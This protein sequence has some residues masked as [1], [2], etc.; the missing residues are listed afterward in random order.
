MFLASSFKD[1]IVKIK[2][3]FIII[4][5][6]LNTW[7]LRAAH[8]DVHK[9]EGKTCAKLE[10]RKRMTE[11]LAFTFPRSPLLLPSKLLHS[12]RKNLKPPKAEMPPSLGWCLQLGE[13][14]NLLWHAQDLWKPS[15][16]T[17]FPGV[18]NKSGPKS[19]AGTTC[20]PYFT[21]QWLPS[22]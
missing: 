9:K 6:S 1:L 18:S 4:I 17:A 20:C 3:C 14:S 5:I 12:C 13:N 21:G 15:S 2:K 16:A 7:I 11:T 10:R 22:S 19:A 8:L